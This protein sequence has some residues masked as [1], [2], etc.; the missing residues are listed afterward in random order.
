[1]EKFLELRDKSVKHLKA[2]EQTI[3]F[4]YPLVRENRVLLSA[5]NHLFLASTSIMGSLLSYEERNKRI[6]GF[7]DKFEE[8]FHLL[9]TRVA[10]RYNID[11]EYLR[12]MRDLKDLIIAHNAS[13]VEFSRGKKL[14]ICSDNYEL[15]EIT[16]EN[17]KNVLSKT[18][19]FIEDVILIT[20]K[21]T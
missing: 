11:P 20:N 1:M 9:K 21:G 15:K 6:P 4:T 10:D 7:E 2:A 12:M 18:K 19:L 5:V 14:V 13:P 17:L 16:A 3:N 8:K